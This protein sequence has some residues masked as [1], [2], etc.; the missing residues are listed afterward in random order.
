MDNT[1]YAIAAV[2]VS[3][4]IAAVAVAVYQ[5]SKSTN[6][7]SSESFEAPAPPKPP[8][9]TTT[10]YQPRTSSATSSDTSSQPPTSSQPVAQ[11]V[12]Q[13]ESKE[14]DADCGGEVKKDT[15]YGTPFISQKEIDDLWTKHNS[16]DNYSCKAFVTEVFAVS[17]KNLEDTNEVIHDYLS[18]GESTEWQCSYYTHSWRGARN[19]QEYTAHQYGIPQTELDKVWDKHMS[20]DPND[21]NNCEDYRVALT[22]TT[23]LI[24]T[25]PISA[26]VK[27]ING[28]KM[29]FDRGEYI[30][31]LLFLR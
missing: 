21:P 11:P 20:K 26:D 10:T 24:P 7:S 12:P 18:Q 23:P 25:G 27:D 8:Y 17:G 30:H 31:E 28:F 9:Q 22:A 1:N 4:I 16:S 29:N 15:F 6:Q 14:Y 3:I 5:M 13:L 19:A 2:I